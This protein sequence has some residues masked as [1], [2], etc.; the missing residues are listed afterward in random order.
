MFHDQT[1]LITGGTGS[2]GQQLTRKLLQWNP[3]EIRILSRNEFAQVLMRRL[4]PPDAPLRFLI[5]D[6]R[7]MQA[8]EQ[9]S[10]G[11]NTI[12]HLAALKHVPICEAQPEEALKTNVQGTQNVIR[13]ALCNGVDK[14]IDVST[15]KAV[16]PVNFYGMT[17]AFGERLTIQANTTDRH[18]RFVCIRGGNVLGTNG[19]VVPYFRTLLREGSEIPLTSREMTRFFLSMDEAIGLLV[20]AAQRAVGGETYVMKM[21]SCRIIDL[22][23]V[24]HQHHGQKPLK[25]KEIGVRPGEKIHEVLV[26]AHESPDTRHLDEQY[27]VIVHPTT[28]VDTVARYHYL[29]PVDFDT[30]S[31]ADHLMEPGEIETMLAKAGLLQ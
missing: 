7:E 4:F 15:D 23:E 20:Q 21:K 2:W 5:G 17:K 30:Y 22:I 18:T 24:M 29:K 10:R 8:V 6:V 25:I 31:S 28:P 3:R 26:S 14:V 19:S 27:F 13:A 11:V 16:D 9:A 1:I 12:F